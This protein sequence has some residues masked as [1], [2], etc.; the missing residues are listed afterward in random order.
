M[1]KILFILCILITSCD[2]KATDL[3]KCELKGDVSSVK[4]S[5]YEADSKFG[6]IIKGDYCDYYTFGGQV[7]TIE[8]NESGYITF[9]SKFRKNGKLEDKEV[10]SYKNGQVD[11][12]NIYDSNGDLWRKEVQEWDKNK[13]LSQ[14]IFTKDGKED[15]KFIYEYE[16]NLIK[17][18]S[19]YLNGELYSKTIVTKHNGK[20]ISEAIRY[21]KDGKKEDTETFTWEN[22]QCVKYT[23][24]SMSYSREFN[25]SVLAIKSE[26]CYYIMGAIRLS[27]NENVFYYE[28]EY[29]NKDNWIKCII[30]EGEV[31]QPHFIVERKITYR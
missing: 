7:K 30:Y 15:Y 22:N 8:F 25:K 21:D 20:N 13:L 24:N 5:F 16:N 26:N 3:E 4:V 23:S 17:S 10:Y 1:K 19:T 2:N 27:D 6:E 9:L 28:Y 29:D 11:E 12:I 31:K 14:T 18:H